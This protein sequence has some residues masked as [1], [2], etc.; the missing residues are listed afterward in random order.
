MGYINLDDDLNYLGKE[1]DCKQTL[2]NHVHGEINPLT[3]KFY[4]ILDEI[5]DMIQ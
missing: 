4:N 5:P 1:M 3:H 2:I